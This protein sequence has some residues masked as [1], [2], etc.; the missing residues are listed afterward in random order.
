VGGQVRTAVAVT[1]VLGALS[2]ALAAVVSGGPAAA[3]AA[4]GFGMVLVFF[5]AGAA[6]VNVV[7]SISPALSLV[8]ALLTYTLQV[9]MVA[10]VFTALD[11]SG[12]LDG[13]IDRAWASG[14]VIVATLVW[15]ASHIISVTRSRHPVYDL[16]E[17]SGNGQEAGA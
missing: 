15:L 9:V 8:V 17:R 3:G 2:V 7:A 5:G 11:R 13:S 1:I 16:P 10:V 6:L 12:A 14:A 4:V